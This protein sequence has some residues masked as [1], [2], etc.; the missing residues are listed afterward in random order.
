MC[1]EDKDIFLY[2]KYFIFM[3]FKGVQLQFQV[4]QVP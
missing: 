3:R 4:S 2:L 1:I